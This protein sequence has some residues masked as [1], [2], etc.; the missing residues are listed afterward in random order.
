MASVVCIYDTHILHEQLYFAGELI[1]LLGMTVLK[2][3]VLLQ[4]LRIFSFRIWVYI[5]MAISTSYGASFIIATLAGCRP[6]TYN[7]HRWQ[8]EESGTCINIT[9]EIYAS[10]VINIILDGI[11]TLLPTTQM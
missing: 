1:Y 11:I 9:R 4:Y 8:A 2:I 10:A 3:S 5:L 7:F 6:L